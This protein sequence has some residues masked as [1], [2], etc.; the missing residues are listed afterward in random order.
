MAQRMYPRL[1]QRRGI[2]QG[3]VADKT[4]STPNRIKSSTFDLDRKWKFLTTDK[5]SM[6]RRHREL[7]LQLIQ[8]L[9]WENQ[10]KITAI[11]TKEIINQRHASYMLS[12]ATLGKLDAPPQKTHRLN[13]GLGFG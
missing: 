9:T 1:Q 3:I 5:D 4:P 2:W 7:I 11:A 10:C 12:P 13:S 6:L 8:Q